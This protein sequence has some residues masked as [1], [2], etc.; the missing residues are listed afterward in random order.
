M[1]LQSRFTVDGGQ[2]TSLQP[3]DTIE[4]EPNAEV[5][6][7]KRGES[8]LL[9]RAGGQLKLNFS[10]KFACGAGFL[11]FSELIATAAGLGIEFESLASFQCKLI[12]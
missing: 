5:L 10:M 1:R 7:F 9:P 3:G 12:A 2:T 11:E 6:H 4:Y 8:F